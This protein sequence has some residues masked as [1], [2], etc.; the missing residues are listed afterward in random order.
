MLIARVKRV[1]ASAL[2]IGLATFIAPANSA[3]IAGTK[4]TKIGA[5]K[6]V[7]NIK[8]TCVK[9]GSKFIWNKGVT[10]VPVVKPTP[11]PRPSQMATPTPSPTSSPTQEQ[12]SNP[13]P[14]PTPTVTPFEIPSQPTSFS[15]L[16]QNISGIPYSAWVKS[17]DKIL[18]SQ[19][20]LGK[21]NIL[22]GPNTRPDN[23]DPLVAMN[24]V[25][26]LFS[27]YTQPKE[28]QLMYASDLDI[29]WGQNQINSFCGATDCGYNTGGE[30]KKACNIPVT[31]CWGAFA[32]RNQKT[33]I[34]LMY[35]TASD[36]G[37]TDLNHIQG[38]L[39]A[40]EYF[41][42]VQDIA[43]QQAGNGRMPR[44]LVE[45]SASWVQPAAVFYKDYDFYMS[46]RNRVAGYILKQKY[47]ASFLEDYLNPS[48]GLDWS[49]WDK[50]QDNFGFYDIGL[51]ATEVMASVG[52]P[53]SVLALFKRVGD[54]QTFQEAFQS[55]FGISWNQGV[56]IIAE[57]IS[58]ESQ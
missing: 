17:H 29:D 56:K 24:L 21:T 2:V 14:S 35:Q 52:G 16:L 48:T 31:P 39:E 38:T 26:R 1:I 50:Y 9:Q 5:T 55:E 3:T 34:P 54:G 33:G 8:Y 57:V 32:A 23:S 4:C 46:E 47:S 30:A 10:I 41:H 44:W 53:N 40:H 12:N 28:V 42:T 7:S 37:K 13:K 25:S 22:I 27:E 51:L 36:W 19:S 15:N 11:T 45:G 58:K 6:T 20:V 18:K 43:V 49:S